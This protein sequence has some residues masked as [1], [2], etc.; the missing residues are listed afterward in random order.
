MIGVIRTQ[1]TGLARTIADLRERVRIAVAGELGRA[2][3]GAVQQVIQAVV[4][5]QADPPRPSATYQRSSPS[6]WEDSE[7]RWNRPYD[8]WTDDPDDAY[9]RDRHSAAPVPSDA[10]PVPDRGVTPAIAAGVYAARWWLGRQGT[11]LA[12]ATLGLGIGL[13]GVL[14]G[15]IARTAVAVLAAT[16]DILSATDA[17]GD[18]ASRFDP[19]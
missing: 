1:L 19:S 12:A 13:L 4:A 11:L 14:G 8:P 2:I 3:S 15:P 7:D 18:R 16:A 5:G 10:P 17:L 6:R 9:D